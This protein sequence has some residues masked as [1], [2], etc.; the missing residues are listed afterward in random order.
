MVHFMGITPKSL[1]SNWLK[2]IRKANGVEYVWEFHLAYQ[3]RQYCCF[4]IKS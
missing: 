1:Q 2:M 4:G 3:Q